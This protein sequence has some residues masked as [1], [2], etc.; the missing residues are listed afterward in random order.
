[1]PSYFKTKNFKIEVP[2]KGNVLQTSLQIANNK[3]MKNM[4]VS[5]QCFVRK[6]NDGFKKIMNII[7][8]SVKKT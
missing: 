6:L 5:S 2:L 7:L 8:G 1:V 4:F 3:Y